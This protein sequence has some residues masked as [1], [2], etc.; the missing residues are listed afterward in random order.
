MGDKDSSD[1]SEIKEVKIADIKDKF[2]E[3][4]KEIKLL[5]RKKERKEN[6]KKKKRSEILKKFQ[7]ELNKGINDEELKMGN[8]LVGK[9]KIKNNDEK[10]A[11]KKMYKKKNVMILINNKNETYKSIPQEVLDFKDQHFYGGRIKREKNFLG[12]I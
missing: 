3:E 9:K 4:E 1:E 10:I 11:N 8:L 7:E 12:K 5:K 6:K 2:I